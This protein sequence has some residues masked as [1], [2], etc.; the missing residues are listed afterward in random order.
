MEKGTISFVPVGAEGRP[1]AGQIEKGKYSLTTLAPGD[2]AMPG[3]YK[4]TVM[5]SDVDTTEMKAIAKGGQFHHDEA[6]AKAAKGAKALV[7]SKYNLA[8]TSGLEQEV[9]ASTNSFN[10]PL[11]D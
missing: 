4:V 6:F 5:S 2:G 10:F 8:E 7:P 9:K 3:K 11:V 1:A